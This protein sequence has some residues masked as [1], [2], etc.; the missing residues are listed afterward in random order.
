MDG[1]GNDAQL[2]R[3]AVE[4]VVHLL[5]GGTPTLVCCGA[6][7]SRSPIIA[8]AAWSIHR[9]ESPQE[10]LRAITQSKPRDV[11]PLLWNDVI[12]ACAILRRSS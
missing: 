4:T 12:K 1:E 8:A 7:M 2:L 9:N 6:G 5:A 11:S 3:L 10:T